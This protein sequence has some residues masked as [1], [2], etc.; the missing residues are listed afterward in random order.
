[1]VFQPGD[2]KQPPRAVGV[3]YSR[4]CRLYDPGKPPGAPADSAKKYCYARREII[5]CGG[6]FNTPQILMLSGIGDS[7]HLKHPKIA[8]PGMAGP[9]GDVQEGA[10]IHLPGV[11]R[12]LRDRYEISV[13]SEI[14]GCFTTLNGVRFEPFAT[15]DP[16]L[17]T[18]KATGTLKPRGGLYTTNGAALAILKRSRP[19]G[20]KPPDLLLLGFPA[21]FRGYYPGWS[22]DLLTKP[23][24]GPEAGRRQN[25]WSWTILK[26]YS[27]NRGTLRLRSGNPFESPEIDFRYFGCVAG[28]SP[29]NPD[30]EDLAALKFGVDYVRTLNR[31]ASHLMKNGHAEEA[32]ILP[33]PAMKS[34]SPELADWIMRETWGHHACG[35]C[36]IGSDPWQAD[37]ARLK[38]KEAV[39]DSSFRVHGVRGLRVVDASVF[40]T[41]PGY[42]IA[43]PVYLAGEKAADT[44][45]N[46]LSY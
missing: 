31:A 38:D 37:P 43:V 28:S 5:L 6:A 44:I 10:F 3:E 1:V 17:N 26:A 19:E 33:G 23:G 22:K 18:W 14:D 30:D 8:I 45:L 12:N 20:A 32:E 4:G 25:L 16:A 29:A 13:I 11:G 21:A 27:N 40:P 35:T 41:I 34:G 15:D 2:R 24:A 7:A 46:E 39:L 42:F 9:R 36:R